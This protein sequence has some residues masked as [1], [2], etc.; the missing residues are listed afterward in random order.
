MSSRVFIA[1]LAIIII[2]FAVPVLTSNKER[3]AQGPRPGTGHKELGRQHVSGLTGRP[4]T[5]LEIDTS[6]NH[7]Q[8]PLPWQVF[9]REVP[10][11]YV[12]HNL[13][14]GGIYIS[15]KPGLPAD[16]VA[17]IKGLFSKPYARKGFSPIKAVVA[18]REANSAPIV[19]SSWTRSMRL[20]KYDEEKMVEYYMRNYGQAPEGTAS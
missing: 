4:N 9:D 2:G 6:G 17:K 15:Y 7:D 1:V 13:E 16:Q 19:M 14:H 3:P 8:S 20:D 5:K 11:A 18:P 12:I 10:D